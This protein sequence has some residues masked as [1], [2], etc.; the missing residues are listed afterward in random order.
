[1]GSMFRFLRSSIGSSRPELGDGVIS[2]GVLPPCA[3]IGI[4]KPLL[5]FWTSC[6]SFSSFA[7][8][9]GANQ[10]LFRQEEGPEEVTEEVLGFVRRLQWCVTIQLSILLRL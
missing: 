9:N 1:M 7:H 2:V 8:P 3:F 6:R 5:M 4:N 10:I